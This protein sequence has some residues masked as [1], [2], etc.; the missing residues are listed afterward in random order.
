MEPFFLFIVVSVLQEYLCS[1]SD[2]LF[3]IN[4]AGLFLLKANITAEVA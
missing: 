1:K 4:V 2:K 3:Y